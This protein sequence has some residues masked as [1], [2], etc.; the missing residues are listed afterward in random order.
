MVER[1]LALW[2]R[3]E[4]DNRELIIL[5][6]GE[7]SIEGLVP[8]HPSIRY[9]RELPKRN[10]GEK[11]N[12]LFEFS[13]GEYCVVWDDDDLY[14]RD[15][16]TK[17]LQPFLFDSKVNLVGTST[18]YYHNLT[19]NRVY[20]YDNAKPELEFMHRNAPHWLGAPMIRKSAWLTFG[21]WSGKPFG[22]DYEFIKRMTEGT[23]IDLH[24]REL[25]VCTIH[26][27]NAAAKPKEFAVGP[28]S[29]WADASMGDL[30]W[31]KF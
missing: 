17:L 4:Y 15:R 1:S 23:C 3:Q 5:D 10:H 14:A 29:V 8:E 26:D 2:F 11:M 9:Y 13:K 7:R 6:D 30:P 21:P 19:D 18:T 31:H 27:S 20:L 12:R 28:S 22:A 24:D 16:F 25:M